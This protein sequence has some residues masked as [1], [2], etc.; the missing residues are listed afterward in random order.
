MR[1][2]FDLINSNLFYSKLKQSVLGSESLAHPQIITISRETGSGGGTIAYLLADKLGQPWKVYHEEIVNEI[3]EKTHLEKELISEIDEHRTPFIEQIMLDFFGKRY[4]NLG[5]YHKQ[6]ARIL[7]AIGQRG[8]AIVIGRGANFLLPSSLKIRIICDMKHR[9]ER[10]MKIR[11]LSR[12][13]AKKIIQTSDKKRYEL[14]K[15]LYGHDV[16]KAHHY[17][18]VIRIDK[19]LTIEDAVE[20]ILAAAERRFK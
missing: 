17:D 1:K 4:L 12:N 14:I 15:A 13:E 6:L 2:I 8:K 3:A 19:N 5:A 7:S 9:V 10:L 18:L 20:V 11:N 16:K